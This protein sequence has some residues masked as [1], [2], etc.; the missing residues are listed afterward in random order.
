MRD[1]KP[2]FSKVPPPPPET[3]LKPRRFNR[4]RPPAALR[5]AERTGSALAWF[6]ALI[7]AIETGDDEAADRSR[8]ELRRLG[9][10]VDRIRQVAPGSAAEDEASPLGRSPLDSKRAATSDN[11]RRP[12]VG[13]E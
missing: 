4:R 13:S 1:P 9:W 12:N 10:A 6:G 7:E 3:K 11:G 5:F 2:C 8:D